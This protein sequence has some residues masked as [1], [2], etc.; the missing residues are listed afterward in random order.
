MAQVKLVGNTIQLEIFD[1]LHEAITSEQRQELIESLTCHNEVI[2]HV[3]EQLVDGYTYN[4]YAGSWSSSRNTAIQ[5]ARDAIYA[6]HGKIEERTLRELKDKIQYL[7]TEL[8]KANKE[9]NQLKYPY[10][11]Y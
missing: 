3:V 6:A 11:Q 9:L 5:N 7:E 4:G 2:N 10:S 1:V 8:V